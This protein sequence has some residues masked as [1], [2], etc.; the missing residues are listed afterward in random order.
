MDMNKSAYHIFDYQANNRTLKPELFPGDGK[1]LEQ[2]K[3]LD[4]APKPTLY[5]EATR[6]TAYLKNM[7]E[8]LVNVN[9]Q[10]EFNLHL[11]HTKDDIQTYKEHLDSLTKSLDRLKAYPAPLNIKTCNLAVLYSGKWREVDV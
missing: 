10:Y 11:K 6:L 3:V 8:R 2:L 5:S 7:H 1:K 4:N 9:I